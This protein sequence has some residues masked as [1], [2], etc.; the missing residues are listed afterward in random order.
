MYL[1]YT[2]LGTLKKGQRVS[3]LGL[4]L[5]YLL[6]R[7]LNPQRVILH[8]FADVTDEAREACMARSHGKNAYA[9]DAPSTRITAG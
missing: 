8:R 3:S 9:H 1:P 6:G 5:N 7:C 4:I 2:K